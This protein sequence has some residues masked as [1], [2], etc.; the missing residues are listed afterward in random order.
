MATETFTSF[1]ENAPP[2][3]LPPNAADLIPVVQNGKTCELPVTEF[4]GYVGLGVVSSL[5]SFGADP[6][7]ITDSTDAINAWLATA[8]TGAVLFAPKG[9]YKFT[10]SLTTTANADKVTIY[11]SGPNT[12]IFN[13]AGMSTTTDLLTLGDGVTNLTGWY[14]SNFRITSNTIMTAG[15]ALHIKRLSASYIDGVI[16]DG[17]EL[18][19]NKLWNG[20]Y[21]DGAHEVGLDKFSAFGR[22]DGVIV[23]GRDGT[24][25]NNLYLGTGQLN[26]NGGVGLHIAGGF[27]GVVTGPTE[28]FGNVVANIAID[29]SLI[30]VENREII[31]SDET[32]IDGFLTT[33]TCILIN[34]TLVSGGN[35]VINAFIGSAAQD[36]ILVTSWPNSEISIG[37]GRLYNAGRD[38]IRVADATTIIQISDSTLISQNIGWGIN[39]T[40]STN[41]IK[42]SGKAFTNTAGNFA[43]NTKVGWQSYVPTVSS[44]TGS[45][46]TAVATARYL[47]NA[48]NQ[49]QL[50]ITIA[51]TT[52]GS[53]AS[54]ITADLPF[55]SNA[56]AVLAGREYTVGKMLQGAIAN[57]GATTVK[58]INFDNTY[59]A[60]DGSVI[61]VSGV[62]ESQ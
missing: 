25:N 34:D 38:G 1:I 8:T 2:A 37:S 56:N 54:W 18:G 10:G 29:N 21:F 12:T 22:G 42:F 19:N 60:A 62:Y 9:T 13:Y 5:T 6:T 50:E 24:S 26:Q 52:N 14:L 39:A 44:G 41:N 47:K 32:I 55:T 46:T 58:I 49:V 4:L 43:P 59:P 27:G 11:G 36:N 28:F 45:L 61:V 23:V 35:I 7:G 17:S 51:V 53:G 48:Q 30:A 16:C 20:F 3:A 40:V 57:A 33:P 15:A 31:I